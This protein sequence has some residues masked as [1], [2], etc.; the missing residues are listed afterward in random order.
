MI[1]SDSLSYNIYN[2]DELWIN[3]SGTNGRYQVSQEGQVY[4]CVKER[5]LQLP[6][7]KIG[8]KILRIKIDNEIKSIYVH[9]LV[10]SY[11]IPNINN[12]DTVNHKDLNKSNNSVVNLEWAT[13]KENI[14][15]ARN[16]R[17]WDDNRISV[18]IYNDTSRF[19]FPSITL[20]EKFIGCSHGAISQILHG[21]G[22]TVYGYR[23]EKI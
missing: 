19:N 9:R 13:M 20:A 1:G 14:T 5:Y 21:K 10:A 7:N 15:H 11:F 17:E 6:A 4:D 23:V 8:Y 3:I 16:N 22:N 18:S 12:K 2:E